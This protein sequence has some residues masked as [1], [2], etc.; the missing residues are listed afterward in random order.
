MDYI[1]SLLYPA[2]K[3]DVCLTPI[4][5]DE[6]LDINVFRSLYCLVQN[7]LIDG[8]GSIRDEGGS[9]E[10]GLSVKSSLSQLTNGLV[11]LVSDK[12]HHI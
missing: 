10:P 5:F 8:H 6:G 1:Q 7:L 12:V 11:E 4:L 2:F 9:L 3:N